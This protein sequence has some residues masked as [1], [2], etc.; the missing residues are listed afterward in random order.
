MIFVFGFICGLI[1]PW[2]VYRTIEIMKEHSVFIDR[3]DE[4][5]ADEVK[6]ESNEE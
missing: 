4:E 5:V 2:I 6:E 1:T 3:T